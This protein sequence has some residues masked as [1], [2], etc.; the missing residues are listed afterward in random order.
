MRISVINFI[1]ECS[2]YGNNDSLLP[3][4]E[5]DGGSYE[6]TV[7][8]LKDF[9]NTEEGQKARANNESKVIE[10]K[11]PNGN[12]IKTTMNLKDLYV[13]KVEVLND[14]G[15]TIAIDS[16][17][18]SDINDKSDNYTNGPELLPV[19]DYQDERKDENNQVK[20]KGSLIRSQAFYLAEAVRFKKEF[21]NGQQSPFQF[22]YQNRF[23]FKSKDKINGESKGKD[24]SSFSSLYNNWA[25]TSS[26][27]N[28]KFVDV[29]H[30]PP[31][32][33]KKKNNNQ[34]NRRK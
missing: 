31:V 33:E 10:E 2:A 21:P 8:G 12:T 6:T 13:T 16:T 15:E 22:A 34:N 14:K 4:S 30:M 1:I 17:E 19:L 28:D 23:G 20:N 27:S 3:P 11:L 26:E 29:K 5:L 7:Q 25:K 18:N 32:E 24:F 9:L